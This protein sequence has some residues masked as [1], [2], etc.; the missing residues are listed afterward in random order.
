MRE[1]GEK[2][3]VGQVMKGGNQSRKKG[4]SQRTDKTENVFEVDLSEV[5]TKQLSP[6][7]ARAS[8]LQHK[9]P[10]DDSI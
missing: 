9:K 4:F 2:E 3:R 1:K 7:L 8:K 6:N 5:N 10:E